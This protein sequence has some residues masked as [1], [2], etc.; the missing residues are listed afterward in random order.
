MLVNAPY[1][2]VIFQTGVAF[3]SSE[4]QRQFSGSTEKDAKQ[5]NTTGPGKRST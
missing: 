2:N 5:S 1:A 4:T 3:S